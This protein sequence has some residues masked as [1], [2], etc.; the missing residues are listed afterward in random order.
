MRGRWCVAPD[1]P[2]GWANHG[3]L[4]HSSWLLLLLE[5]HLGRPRHRRCRRLL[6]GSRHGNAWVLGRWW[7]LNHVG[8]LLLLRQLWL[9]RA[10][11]L[12]LLLS[13][14]HVLLLQQLPALKL[15]LAHLLPLQLLRGGRLLLLLGLLRLLATPTTR[16]G[17]DQLP[18]CSSL[19]LLLL[20]EL[21]LV[22]LQL[23]LLPECRLLLRG[24][25]VSPDPGWLAG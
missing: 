13:L 21:C 5:L 1:W 20:L 14:Q 18:S 24:K 11:L 7:P 17:R 2:V 4:L 15:G 6:S 3:L 25:A 9:G 8:L 19:L 23:L 12:L 22:Q 10:L 16:G